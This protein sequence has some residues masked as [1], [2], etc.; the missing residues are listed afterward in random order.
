MPARHLEVINSARL[1][2]E[3]RKITPSG[4][5]PPKEPGVHAFGLAFA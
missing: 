4:D 3:K 2:K 5:L 1:I